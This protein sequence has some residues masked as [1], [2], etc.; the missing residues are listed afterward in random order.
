VVDK[1][2]KVE[3]VVQNKTKTNIDRNLTVWQRI[4]K[5]LKEAGVDDRDF[6][7]SLTKSLHA[8]VLAE[9]RDARL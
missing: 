9:R 5:A 4:D 7:N 2:L 6:R 3:F 8:Y 1:D